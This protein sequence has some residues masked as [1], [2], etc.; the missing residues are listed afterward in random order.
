MYNVTDK[1]VSCVCDLQYCNN[2]RSITKVPSEPLAV[3]YW[4]KYVPRKPK[5][6]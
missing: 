1:L 3:I 4:H 2:D 5:I 6:A